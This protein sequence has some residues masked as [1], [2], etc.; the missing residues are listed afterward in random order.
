VGQDTLPGLRP[1]TFASPD[2]TPSTD[3]GICSVCVELSPEA[4]AVASWLPHSPARPF[5]RRTD[6]LSGDD[7]ELEE[8]ERAVMTVSTSMTMM[9]INF[10]ASR[11]RIAPTS[12]PSAVLAPGLIAWNESP[13]PA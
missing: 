6:G 11:A 1:A 7:K 2:D 5:W 12:L 8:Q 10:V 4:W 3:V 9:A 13:A